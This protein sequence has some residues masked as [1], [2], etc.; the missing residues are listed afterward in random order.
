MEQDMPEVE[1]TARDVLDEDELADY[2]RQGGKPWDH[3][4]GG[5]E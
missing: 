4:S 2:S 3:A 5:E 1:W